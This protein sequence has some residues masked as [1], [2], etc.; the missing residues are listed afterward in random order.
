MDIK[1]NEN[2]TVVFDLDDTLYYEL[3]YLISAYK[4]I[5][6]FLD[7]E[8]YK[9]LFS[10]MFSM[11]RNQL[12]VFDFLVGKYEVNKQ[13]LVEK[14]RNHKPNIYLSEG[15]L[16]VIKSIKENRGKVAII[17]DGRKITQMNKI[18]ALQIEEYVDFIS[19]SEEIGYEKPSKVPFINVME[20][21]SSKEYYYVADNLKKDF[22]SPNKLGWISIALIDL[23]KNI[24]PNSFQ[25][26]E[27][28]YK[29]KN[30]IYSFLEINIV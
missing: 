8:Q 4:E 9:M 13:D 3:D 18:R 20:R 24:H 19:I 14:Y 2:T 23:G 21:F 5:A 10:V 6:F 28:K 25:F 12:D 22:I 29:P 15:V 27:K 30:L 16:N 17:T 1:V 26:L 11:Y 7:E